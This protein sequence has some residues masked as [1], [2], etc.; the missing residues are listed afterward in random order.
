[1][2]KGRRG[3]VEVARALTAL[4]TLPVEVNPTTGLHV[5]VSRKGVLGEER[6]PGVGRKPGNDKV[7]LQRNSQGGAREELGLPVFR[8]ALGLQGVGSRGPP[9]FSVH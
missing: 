6:P 3:L 7:Q 8:T 2:L 4:N 9:P 1:V 5:H